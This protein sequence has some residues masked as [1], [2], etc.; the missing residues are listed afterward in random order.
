MTIQYLRP[1]ASAPYPTT[2]TAWL[3]L[4]SQGPESTPPL[5][6]W[7]VAALMVTTTGY[8]ATA[9]SSAAA[10]LLRATA[11]APRIQPTRILPRLH[12]P[13]LLS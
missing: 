4:A 3:V 11:A 6:C 7:K 12:W 1:P 10:S 8:R 2:V 9:S 13:C 5:E